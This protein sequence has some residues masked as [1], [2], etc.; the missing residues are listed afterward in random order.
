MKKSA[1][2]SLAEVRRK[3]NDAKQMI[4]TL[5]ALAKLRELRKDAAKKKGLLRDSIDK[6]MCWIFYAFMAK[7]SYFM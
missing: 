1:D 3:V 4:D 5:K 2:R 6:L 7:F